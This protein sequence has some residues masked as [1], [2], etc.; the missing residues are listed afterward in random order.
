VGVNAEKSF[1]TAEIRSGSIE[2]SSS[3][4]A[5][6]LLNTSQAE[7]YVG[8]IYAI[9]YAPRWPMPALV[10]RGCQRAGLS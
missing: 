4:G 5:G 2:G 7:N 9:P 6:E 8:L 10:G 1:V 3:V